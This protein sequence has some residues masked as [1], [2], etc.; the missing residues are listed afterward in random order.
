MHLEVDGGSSLMTSFDE[1]KVDN[2]LLTIINYLKS[3]KLFSSKALVLNFALNFPRLPFKISSIN[4]RNIKSPLFHH[5]KLSKENSS[6]KL[7]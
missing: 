2:F 5:R 7:F 4:S 6:L 1:L 3:F